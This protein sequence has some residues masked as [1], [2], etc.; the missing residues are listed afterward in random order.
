MKKLI[1]N[2]TAS[3]AILCIIFTICIPYFNSRFLKLRDKQIQE[4]ID[5]DSIKL[6]QLKKD[7][8]IKFY[9][10]GKFEPSTRED[11]VLIPAQLSMTNTKM[12]LRKETLNAFIKMQNSA[13]NDG[14][15][16]KIA[17]ATRNFEYQKNLWDN[18]WTGGTLVEG[19]DLSKSILDG[20]DRFLKIL[21]YSAAP[22]TSRHHW[23]TDIDINDAN[24][25]Y[26]NTKAGEEV[27]DWLVLNAPSFG[28]CQ[29]Y[30]KK[31]ENRATGYNEE[32][33]HW[34]YLPLAKDF[35]RE[36]QRLVTIDDIK[37]FKG[38]E[39]ASSEDIDL[40]TNYVFSIN[41]DCL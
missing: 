31:D 14:I 18:K 12:Y 15:D 6:Q 26:F 5:K 4:N 41:P 22:S 36:Y 23:G 3:L 20:K 19:K 35:T 38:E 7:N 29:T 39:Y 8:E 40:I 24:P 11:F 30:T 13:S 28:F 25:Q 17:S 37:G 9:L 21:E 32:K 34:S 2:I 27:Y 10:T 33:W 1:P 16:L